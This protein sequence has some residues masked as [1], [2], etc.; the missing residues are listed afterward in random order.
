MGQT[1]FRRPCSGS[2]ANACFAGT[3]PRH[4]FARVLTRREACEIRRS[5]YSGR[6]AQQDSRRLT[7]RAGFGDELLDF[8]L[9]ARPASRAG[10]ALGRP[11]PG[12][13]AVC[14][15]GRATSLAWPAL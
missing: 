7:V 8:I 11:A 4:S 15:W 6:P 13:S 9:G 5:R 3:V 12:G 10:C 2:T 14:R 1:G